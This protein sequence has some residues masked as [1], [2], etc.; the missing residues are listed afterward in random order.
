[1]LTHPAVAESA[2]LGVP[3]PTWG[4]A[5]VMVCVLRA[6][7]DLSEDELLAWMAP[8]MARYKLPR[9]IFWDELPRSGYGKDEEAG[10]RCAVRAAYRGG[11][12]ALRKY[13]RCTEAG[14]QAYVGARRSWT[15]ETAAL[16]FRAMLVNSAGIGQDLPFLDTETA[17]LRRMLEVNLVGSFV[18]AREVARRMRK[19]GHGSIVNIT[20]VS[21][22][23][24]NAGRAAYGASKGGW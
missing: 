6:G 19:R 4:E 18:V 11:A 16:R 22:I 9:H 14:A 8:R 10:A 20:S 21:G 13:R 2:V 24:G 17:A 15:P 5:G 12:G 3:D 23:R 1:M 7:H